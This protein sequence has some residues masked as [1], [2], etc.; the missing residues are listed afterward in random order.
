MWNL[1]GRRF[2]MSNQSKIKYD[3]ERKLYYSELDYPM[4]LRVKGFN[5]YTNICDCIGSMYSFEIMNEYKERSKEQIIKSFKIPLDDILLNYNAIKPDMVVSVIIVENK[6]YGANV[7]LCMSKYVDD[8]YDRGEVLN[9]KYFRWKIGETIVH[10]LNVGKG[11]KE[12]GFVPTLYQLGHIGSIPGVDKYVFRDTANSRFIVPIIEENM[13]SKYLSNTN[14]ILKMDHVYGYYGDDVGELLKMMDLHDQNTIL[15][16]CFCDGIC[17]YD[18]SD[19]TE[20][21]ENIIPDCNLLQKAYDAIGDI[22]YVDMKEEDF[23][24]KMKECRINQDNKLFRVILYR[25]TDF[26]LVG[27]INNY[28]DIDALDMNTLLE[29][30]VSSVDTDRLLFKGVYHEEPFLIRLS[31]KYQYDDIYSN[32]KMYRCNYKPADELEDNDAMSEDEMKVFMDTD[33]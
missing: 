14:K 16:Q 4:D 11:I 10:S 18:V 26:G 20:D 6:H 2:F 15:G 24:N 3:E 27:N 30:P 23:N 5:K 31:D 7:E 32:L 21:M 12:E 28:I 22:Y 33:K 29:T 19:I 9:Q 1:L 17:V 13:S 8:P 25:N